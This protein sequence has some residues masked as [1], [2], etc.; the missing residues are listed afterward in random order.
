MDKP[1]RLLLMVTAMT[2]AGGAGGAGAAQL[3]AIDQ[4]RLYGFAPRSE[5]YAQCRM[6]LRRFWTAGRCGSGRF[7]TAHRGYCHLNLPPF[8]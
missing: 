4:C 3:A 5:D 2:V 6:N 1:L 7:A 8:I